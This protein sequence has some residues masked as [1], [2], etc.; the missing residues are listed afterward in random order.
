MGG[1]VTDM[2][3]TLASLSLGL[4]TGNN[5][6]WLPYLLAPLVLPLHVRLRYRRTLVCFRSLFFFNFHTNKKNKKKRG[7]AL[8]GTSLLPDQRILDLCCARLAQQSPAHS[9]IFCLGAVSFMADCAAVHLAVLC[10]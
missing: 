10:L 7:Q 2:V 8:R 5:G 9:R 4:P 1:V 3:P 6:G